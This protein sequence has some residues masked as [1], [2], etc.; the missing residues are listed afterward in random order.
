MTSSSSS[1]WFLRNVVTIVLLYDVTVVAGGN[2]TLMTSVLME[3]L[4]VRPAETVR[5]VWSVLGQELTGSVQIS[6]SV[7][8]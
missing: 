6:T 2:V 3:S 4:V 5:M 7:Q 1:R 8:T